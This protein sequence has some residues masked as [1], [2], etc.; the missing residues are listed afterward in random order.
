M[1]TDFVIASTQTLTIWSFYPTQQ[2]A[3]EAL[4][5]VRAKYMA[6]AEMCKGHHEKYQHREE[7]YWLKQAARY[8]LQAQDSRVMTWDQFEAIKAERLLSHP[9]EEITE[10]QYEDALNVLPPMRYGENKGIRSF[11]MSEFYSGNYTNQYAQID[12]R[13]F[14]KLV[15]FRNSDTW[16]NRDMVPN[17]PVQRLR[18]CVCGESTTGRQWHNRDTGYGVCPKCAEWVKT[19]GREPIIGDLHVSYY[20]YPGVHYNVEA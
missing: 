15:N 18:C 2:A 8:E 9:I 7:N 6:D 16:I 1:D 14:T 19:S 10:E 17:G 4:P 12:G 5:E 3:E 20:G 11:F 13:Y